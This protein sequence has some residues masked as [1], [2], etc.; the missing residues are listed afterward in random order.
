M[1]MHTVSAIL[2]GTLCCQILGYRVFSSGAES[3]ETP[4]DNA[5]L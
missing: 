3:E 4:G 1:Y 2:G 5:E